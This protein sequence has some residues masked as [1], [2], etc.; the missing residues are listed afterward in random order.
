VAGQVVD[1]TSARPLAGAQVVISGSDRGALVGPDGRF[2]LG[3]LEGTEVTLEVSL[4]GYKPVQRR[5]SVGT[6]D[7]T[8]R[9]HPEAVALEELVVTG[10]PGATRQRELGNEIAKLDATEVTAT[11]APADVQ[12]VLG[13]RISGLRIRDTSGEVGTGG[14][15]TIR[16]VGSLS[17][18]SEP[19]LYIDGVRVDNDPL[20]TGAAFTG[21][22]GG[23]GPSRINDLDPESIQSIEVIKGPAAATLYGTEASNGVIQII[24][25]KGEAGAASVRVHLK[26]GMTYLPNPAQVYQT[27]W[28]RDPVSGDLISQNLVE[29][30]IAGGHG[31]PFSTGWD[32]GYGASVSGGSDQVRLYASGDYSRDEGIVSYNWENK[33]NGRANLTYSP[34]SRFQA[35]LG[36]GLVHSRTSTAS[37]AQPLTTHMIWGLPVLRNGPSR[38]FIANTPE[39][40]RNDVD[41]KEDTDRS[42]VSVTL[43]HDP[44]S[45]LSQ[46]LTLGT[47]V[48][49]VRSKRICRRDPS[50]GANPCFNV[51]GSVQIDQNRSTFQ[52]LDYVLSGTADRLPGRLSSK[53]S[54]GVQYYRK[55]FQSETAQGENLAVPSLE[56]VSA[57]PGDSRSAAEEFVENRTLG[58]YAQER[59]GWRD[60]MFLTLGLR[61]D[62]NSA[63]GKQF[64]FVT[65]PKVSL[66]WILSD[67]PYFDVGFVNTLKLRAAWGRAGQQ[68]NA[69]DAIRTYRATSGPGGVPAL[70]PENLGNPDLKPEVGQEL[71]AGLDASLLDERLALQFTYYDQTTKDA[72]VERPALPSNGFP[73][74]QFVNVGK[75]ANRGFEVG[76]NADVL[77]KDDVSWSL[78]VTASRHSSEVQD[79]GELQ[80]LILPY[81]FGDQR[82]VV[83]FP[84]GALF[85]PEVLS[86]E[87]D[88][89]GNVVNAMC[90]GG[91]PFSRGS[92][93][94]VPCADANPVYRGH[95]LPTWEG[96][97][98]TSVRL[99]GRLELY[100]L[101][102][103]QS[104]GTRVDGDVSASHLFFRNSKCINTSCDPKLAAMDQLVRSGKAGYDIAGILDAGFAKLRTVSASYTLP[105]RYAGLVGADRARVTVSARNLVTLWVAEDG[106]FG[107]KVTDPEIADSAPLSMFTQESWPHD[108]SLDLSIRLAY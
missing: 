85:T 27:N 68:P 75:V 37:A 39:Q 9:L 62:D 80:S 1:A 67:E 7:L 104:G 48:A 19:L 108:T 58:V 17:L 84:I 25:R 56:T 79:L 28:G 30:E 43:E 52:S 45:W 18:S 107:R 60:R 5:V 106:T 81:G 53:T 57:T 55:E 35:R 6:T 61:G 87:F 93:Q 11:S 73:G 102:S 4:V 66:S 24:T 76:V 26:E 14:S 13:S 29:S 103:F 71:E 63:F 46:R 77:Q 74:N 33:L 91:A 105:E 88:G 65:Y 20:G 42:T 38:G 34:S 97:V 40:F 31:S 99:F 50:G 15:T 95:P 41:G 96:S 70:T 86:A 21:C 94:P 8:I 83:G 82:D 98:N 47:D 100:A 2:R 32:Q 92:G 22:G 36:I 69:F 10:T 49:N 101:A 23:C 3:G 89:S 16:G 44:L 90:A 59:I 72:I 64:D 54:V 51:V 12:D 78:G